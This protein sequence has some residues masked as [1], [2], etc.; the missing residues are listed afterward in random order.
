MALNNKEILNYYNLIYP[1]LDEYKKLWNI[2][3]IQLAKYM[4]KEKVDNFIKRHNLSHIANIKEIISDII[5]DIL[6][7]DKLKMNKMK[8]EINENITSTE[9]D[10]S[11][12]HNDID[13]IRIM[14]DYFKTSIGHVS[15]IDENR[16]RI[17][18]LGK[19]DMVCHIY[20]I[21]QIEDIKKDLVKQAFAQIKNNFDNSK[22]YVS[23][24]IENYSFSIN[25]FD[26]VDYEALEYKLNQMNP[27]ETVHFMKEKYNMIY[28]GNHTVENK[29]YHIFKEK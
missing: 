29:N 18:A 12:T 1:L 28:L 11:I 16:Y 26:I 21:K 6:L 20:T 10:G 5:D 23:F 4:K 25:V 27:I 14:A 19:K 2:S 7:N 13:V 9:L 8:S 3:P 15:P 24:D 17:T 22:H